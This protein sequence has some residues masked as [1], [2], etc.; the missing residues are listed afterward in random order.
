MCLPRINGAA[1][2][3]L[4]GSLTYSS[5]RWLCTYRNKSS[6]NYYDILGV[7]PSASLA[8]IKTAFYELSKKY[9]PDATLKSDKSDIRSAMYLEIKDAY[10]VLKDKKKRYEYDLG[11]SDASSY[12]ESH[13]DHRDAVNRKQRNPSNF[14][15]RTP[16]YENDRW[17]EWYRKRQMESMGTRYSR[18]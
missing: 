8:E 15:A 14:Y 17:Y 1:K 5:Y 18:K 4:R 3:S 7:K 13:N 11:F 2:P 12:S 6:K 9:H 10:E 16:Q